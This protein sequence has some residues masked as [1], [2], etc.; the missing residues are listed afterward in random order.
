MCLST[1]YMYVLRLLFT[2]DG[3]PF[4]RILL[5]YTSGENNLSRILFSTFLKFSLGGGRLESV[6]VR[7]VAARMSRRTGWRRPVM[8][9]M[10]WHQMAW[11]SDIQPLIGRA[12]MPGGQGFLTIFFSSFP[13]TLYNFWQL[14][15]SLAKI[16]WLKFRGLNV[17]T[18]VSWDDIWAESTFKNR[19]CVVCLWVWFF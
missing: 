15:L 19:A 9:P 18:Q 11:T 4:G 7:R 14:S 13:T 1:Y 3:F 5:S 12:Q 6:R 17:T 8:T 2:F 10:S 16:F